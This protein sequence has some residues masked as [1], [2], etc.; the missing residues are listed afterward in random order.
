MKNIEL[1]QNSGVDIRSS[2]QLLGSMEFY[3]ETLN[4]FLSEVN[5]T[6]DKIKMYKELNDMENYSVEVHGLKSDS[7]YLGFVKLA[8]LANSPRC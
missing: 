8:E 1:L 7:K 6:L 4:E 2:I 5:N 3:D